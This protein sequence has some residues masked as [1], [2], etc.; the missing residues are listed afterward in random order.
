MFPVTIF[1]RHG[2]I[3]RITAAIK[4]A[5]IEFFSQYFPSSPERLGKLVVKLNP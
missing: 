2:E 1:H 3:T 5:A 4:A